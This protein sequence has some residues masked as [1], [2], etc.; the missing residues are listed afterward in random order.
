MKI[1]LI[2]SN[3]QLGQDLVKALQREHQVIAL[4][5]RDIEVTDLS[6]FLSLKE[7]K[8]DVIIDTAAFHKTDLC[9]DE[10]AQTFLVN[11][12]GPKNVATVSREIGATAIF[13]ST[14]FVFSG[15]K[16]MPYTETDIPSP[17]NTY[18]I[19]KVAGELF[20]QQ[21]P[22]HYIFRVAS[23]FGVAGSSG[24]GGNFVET[25]IG[26][27]RRSEPVTVVDDMWMSPTYTR[28]AAEAVSQ[29]L[30]LNLPFGTYHLT[31]QGA[32]SWYLF[33]KEIFRQA[34][35][36]AE[37]RSMKTAQMQVKAK[38]PLNSALTSVK[39]QEYGIY[40]RS[41]K[42]ALHAYLVEKGHLGEN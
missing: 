25:M 14:D 2:G 9:E 20:I 34:G 3:G 38:R 23:L 4:T 18:G 7:Q 17:I 10:P 40:M 36:E 29:V 37:V 31:N 42:E 39:L 26:K 27:A 13:F 15:S 6:S 24:K 28:D 35:L 22:N 12:V 32:C 30:A 41:W 11:A 1:A 16:G 5:H 33:T 19:S 21:T 8:P